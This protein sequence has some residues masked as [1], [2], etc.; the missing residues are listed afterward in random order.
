MRPNESHCGRDPSSH[1]TGQKYDPI[2]WSCVSNLYGG[3]VNQ[4]GLAGGSLPA[5]FFFEEQLA[6]ES[7]LLAR[8]YLLWQLGGTGSFSG[9]RLSLDGQAEGNR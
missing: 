6:G 2:L 4:E 8:L 7:S 1:F 3:P 5:D 9:W